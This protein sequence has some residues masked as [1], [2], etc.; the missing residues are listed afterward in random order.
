MGSHPPQASQ[1]LTPG[2]AQPNCRRR[3]STSSS[4][5][6]SPSTRCASC[7]RPGSRHRFGIPDISGPARLRRLATRQ[8]RPDR[9]RPR[10]GAAAR[11]RLRDPRPTSPMSLPKCSPTGS[12]C[13]TRPSPTA[14]P[15]SRHRTCARRHTATGRHPE[16][17]QRPPRRCVQ[18]PVQQH[19]A[20]G[21]SLPPGS[22]G[23]APRHR[24]H[25][26]RRRPEP[27]GGCAPIGRLISPGRRRRPAAAHGAD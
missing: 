17:V 19:G 27:S 4:T 26:P 24:V 3:L 6:R 10:P 13:P 14:S 18:R 7:S 23:P 5:T 22:P 21:V 11:S 1:V 8:P 16:P 20:A 25:P 12:S 2:A 15:R 9:R